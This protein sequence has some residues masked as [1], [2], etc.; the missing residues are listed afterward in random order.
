MIEMETIMANST[1]SKTA[2]GPATRKVEPADFKNEWENFLS[3]F[4]KIEDREKLNMLF[5]LFLTLNEKSMMVDRYRLVKS[6]LE[7]EMTQ[8][9]ISE[10]LHLSISKITTGPKAI[11]ILSDE[12]RAYLSERMK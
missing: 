7:G 4:L 10:R 3:L 2:N 12:D 8:R 9:E 11:Q 1:V 5:N 6:L